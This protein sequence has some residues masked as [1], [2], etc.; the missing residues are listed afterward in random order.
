MNWSKL[1]T[2][3]CPKCESNLEEAQYDYK[4]TECDFKIVHYRYD[5]IVSQPLYVP[6]D[7]SYDL[8]KITN[9][10]NLT[11]TLKNPV[12][13]HYH[14]SNGVITVNIW[15]KSKKCMP[16]GEKSFEYDDIYEVIDYINQN[17]PS[18]EK[19]EEHEKSL[20]DI[21]NRINKVIPNP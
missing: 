11:L 18:T 19:I 8:E 2:R 17:T 14:V 13:N 15:A 12:N 9:K 5:E 4:C 3:Q 7:F 20:N 6:Y 21:L 16:F 10:D 1:K